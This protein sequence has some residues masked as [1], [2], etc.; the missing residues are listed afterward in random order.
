MSTHLFKVLSGDTT[1][2]KIKYQF[3]IIC[4]SICNSDKLQHA[5]YVFNELRAIV[6]YTHTHAYIYTYTHTQGM[7]LRVCIMCVPRPIIQ[8]QA[9]FGIYKQSNHATAEQRAFN[10]TFG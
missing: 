2:V 6:S 3:Q 1:Y 4:L 8:C 5:I 10:M 7:L 9:I